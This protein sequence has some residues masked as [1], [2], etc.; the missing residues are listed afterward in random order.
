[1]EELDIDVS[2]ELLLCRIAGLTGSCW[3]FA[4]TKALRVVEEC[5]VPRDQKLR[6]LYGLDA[7]HRTSTQV[8]IDKM[9]QLQR[10]RLNMPIP[11]EER[12]VLLTLAQRGEDEGGEYFDFHARYFAAIQM[13]FHNLA[14][15]LRGYS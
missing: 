2:N 3:F 6:L 11:K 9:G 15:T 4:L 10:M 14:I 13:A 12:R 1:M 5:E 8:Q 7:M